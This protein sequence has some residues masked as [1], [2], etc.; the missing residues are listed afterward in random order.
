ME[1]KQMYSA[2]EIETTDQIQ[3]DT[4]TEIETTDDSMEETDTF[5]EQLGTDPLLEDSEDTEISD[6]ADNEPLEERVYEE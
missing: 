5:G 6:L 1:D 3:T 4:D 2:D